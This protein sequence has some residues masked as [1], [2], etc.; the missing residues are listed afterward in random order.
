MYGTPYAVGLMTG[1]DGTR[2]TVL[3]DSRVFDLDHLSYLEGLDVKVMPTEKGLKMQPLDHQPDQT[4][5][6]LIA[7]LEK[8]RSRRR[9]ARQ[10]WL[11]IRILRS[12][13]Q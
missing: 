12:I 9:H 11:R 13:P 5:G 8:G 4:A 10:N 1:D 7:R 3:T 2:H 6:E